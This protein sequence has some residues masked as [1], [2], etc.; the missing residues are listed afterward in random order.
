MKEGRSAF[1]ILTGK[2]TRKRLLGTPLHR[3]E[4]NIKMDFKEIGVS[5]RSWIGSTQGRVYK[6]GLVNEALN[7]QVT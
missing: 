5:V 3:W 2:P 4:E 7:L 1:K 6:R